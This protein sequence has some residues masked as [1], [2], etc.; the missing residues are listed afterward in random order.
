MKNTRLNFRWH[1]AFALG[2]LVM[3]LFSSLVL[4]AQSPARP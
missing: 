4:D 2:V 1:V 3:L